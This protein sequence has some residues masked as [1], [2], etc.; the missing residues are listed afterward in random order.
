MFFSSE[1]MVN[2]S[3]PAR[4]F[5]NLQ[6][7]YRGSERQAPSVLSLALTF[8]S[9]MKQKA[10][11]GSH[12]KSMNTEQRLASVVSEFHNMNGMLSRWHIDADKLR[13]IM[14]LLMGTSAAAR[15][16]LA[17]HLHFHKWAHSGLTA[18]LLRSSRWLLG[19]TPKGKGAYLKRV[20]TVCEE[21]QVLFVQNYVNGFAIA[22]RRV[23]PSSR[24]RHRATVAEWD[25]LVDYVCVMHEVM[26]E[27]SSHFEQDPQKQ[28]QILATLRDCCM[29]RLG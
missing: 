20:L 2:E 8:S 21:S 4:S 11:S 23:K 14:N 10:D 19:A 17:M 18:E 26:R 5:L 3:G 1:L 12:D 24:A 13:A 27:A 16:A 9:V 6:L 22:T 28:K 7:S 25:K 15:A 29:A